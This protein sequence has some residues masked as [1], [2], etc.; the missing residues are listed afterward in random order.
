MALALIAIVNLILIGIVNMSPSPKFIMCLVLT[1]L[2]VFIVV[3][4]F[5]YINA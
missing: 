4:E 5:L 2:A 3:I 1:V